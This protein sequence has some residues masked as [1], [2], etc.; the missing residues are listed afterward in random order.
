[1]H[2]LVILKF[3]KII[4]LNI[5]LY[6]LSI[7]LLCVFVF[8]M[9]NNANH[10]LSK[11]LFLSSQ[12]L[13]Y[14]Q[15]VKCLKENMFIILNKQ[16]QNNALQQKKSRVLHIYAS[17]YHKQY[18]DLTTY[19][20]MFKLFLVF[21]FF[22]ALKILNLIYNFVALFLFRST[23]HLDYKGKSCGKYRLLY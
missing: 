12:F 1:M 7:Y 17:T 8:N 18:L 4:N 21:H 11:V 2:Y 23:I 9:L 3:Y 14:L 15:M 10:T 13:F 5:I 19:Y 6:I 16:K 20:F 22:A